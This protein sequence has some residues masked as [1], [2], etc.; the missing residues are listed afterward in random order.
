MIS[1]SCRLEAVARKRTRLSAVRLFCFLIGMVFQQIPPLLLLVS[2]YLFL[3]LVCVTRIC[4]N[5]G[6]NVIRICGK[7]PKTC[8]PYMRGKL[9]QITQACGNKRFTA[10]NNSEV[11][12]DT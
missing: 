2:Y 11:G 3:L 7:A 10:Y 1:G 8:Y 4:G 9:S 12:G 5:E 6:G